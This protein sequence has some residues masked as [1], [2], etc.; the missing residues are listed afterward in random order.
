MYVMTYSEAVERNEGTF[1]QVKL[2]REGIQAASL[3]VTYILYILKCT[4]F[5]P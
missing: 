3:Y 2:L 5:R 1:F 4:Y